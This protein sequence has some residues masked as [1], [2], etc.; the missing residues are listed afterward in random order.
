MFVAVEGGNLFE[1]GSMYRP[2]DDL[3]RV[4]E[5]LLDFAATFLLIDAMGERYTPEQLRGPSA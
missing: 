4:R 1:A 3:A 2:M 5:I